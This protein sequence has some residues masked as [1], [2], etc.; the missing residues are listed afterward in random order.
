[1][2]GG[3]ERW[4]KSFFSFYFYFFVMA[5]GETSIVVAW[6]TCIWV[7]MLCGGFFLGGGV[8]FNVFVVDRVVSFWG[9]LL[10]LLLLLE[11]ESL[12]EFIF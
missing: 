12:L 1:M 3:R 8:Q 7:F 6:V 11:Y 9:L 10:L 4:Y 2:Q 5:R